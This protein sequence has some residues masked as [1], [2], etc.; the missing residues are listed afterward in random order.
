MIIIIVSLVLLLLFALSCHAMPCHAMSCLSLSGRR[1]TSLH[2]Q[3]RRRNLLLLPSRCP[4]RI[5]SLLLF[6]F[7]FP[8]RSV[9]HVPV[10]R[11]LEAYH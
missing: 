9:S 2:A 8:T 10:K 11:P 1:L 7:L 5:L 6:L 4:L 3:L